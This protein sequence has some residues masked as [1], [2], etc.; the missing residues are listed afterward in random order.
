MK[1]GTE[2]MVE[3]TYIE[4]SHAKFSIQTT[5]TRGGVDPSGT[6]ARSGSNRSLH[7]TKQMF[8]GRWT[9]K[10]PTHAGR[11]Y[12]QQQRPFTYLPLRR[13]QATTRAC[14]AV[15]AAS[16]PS[17]AHS[18]KPRLSRNHRSTFSFPLGYIV[19]KKNR[20]AATGTDDIEFTTRRRVSCVVSESTT[21]NLSVGRR[22]LCTDV[23]LQ[24]PS[25][26]R[27]GKAYVYRL[28][29]MVG[30]S[31]GECYKM[32]HQPLVLV[33]LLPLIV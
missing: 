14:P 26:T 11:C 24:L 32:C 23:L 12:A 7:P 22:S 20:F 3:R 9:P 13:S 33:N 4:H 31:V 18:W 6:R 1:S 2:P 21:P 10:L 16:S 19:W 28:P 25:V 27:L 15:A 30:L 29:C 17:L 8:D 5:H